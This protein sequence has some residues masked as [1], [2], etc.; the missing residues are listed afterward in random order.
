MNYVFV[1]MQDD[2]YREI[3]DEARP[4]LCED[5]QGIVALNERG[6]MQAVC[7]MDTWSHNAVQIHMWIKNAFVLRHGFAEEIANFIYGS[8]RDLILGVTPADNKMALKFNKHMGMVEQF[9][10]P[11]GYDKGIDY[12]VTVMRKE[13]CRWLE[14]APKQAIG[15]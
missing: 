3:P 13:D 5:T 4:R 6:E 15:G 8:G 7:V 14:Q 11:D 2:M 9:R 12:V 1:S 10:I